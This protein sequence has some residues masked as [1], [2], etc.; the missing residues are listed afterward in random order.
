MGG[1][2]IAHEVALKSMNV[3]ATNAAQYAPEASTKRTAL[4]TPIPR[5]PGL[6][7]KRAG[8]NQ[9]QKRKQWANA[10]HTRIKR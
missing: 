6:I 9:R 1:N 5:I 3:S 8:L 4:G 10:P 2:P 7:T